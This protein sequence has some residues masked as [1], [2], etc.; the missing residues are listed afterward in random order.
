M[1]MHLLCDLS[2]GSSRCVLSLLWFLSHHL[3]W[4][5]FPS[6]LFDRFSDGFR[7]GL[8]VVCFLKCTICIQQNTGNPW[9][10][11]WTNVHSASHFSRLFCSQCDILLTSPSL[12]WNPTYSIQFYSPC[13]NS[14]ALQT[15]P[16]SWQWSI[17]PLMNGSL[18][19]VSESP[20]R[21]KCLLALVMATL[22]LRCS[23]RNPHSPVQTWCLCINS[24]SYQLV[25]TSTVVKYP[26]YP[27]LKSNM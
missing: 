26:N 3:S 16:H 18:H 1:H 24:E 21:A 25:H 6:L 13:R 20:I 14:W 4:Q 12:L 10:C 8:V 17:R 7:S 9:T 19:T 27:L 2:P 22:I 5:L 23:L 15:S 11:Q